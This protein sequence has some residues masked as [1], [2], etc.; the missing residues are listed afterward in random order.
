MAGRIVLCD[1]DN[2]RGALGWPTSASFRNSVQRWAS[3]SVETSLVVIAGDGRK[4]AQHACAIDASY[5]VLRT[6]SGGRWKADDTIVRDVAWWLR[7][8]SNLTICVISSDKQLRSRCRKAGN[9]A[10]AAGEG[11]KDE[12]SMRQ[13]AV[14]K[15][16]FE[17]S[18]TFACW[19]RFG[20][21]SNREVIGACRS[22]TASVPVL[23]GLVAVTDM[24][25]GGSISGACADTGGEAQEVGARSVAELA[26]G[27]DLDAGMVADTNVSVRD[28]LKTLAVAYVAWIE[29]E[30]PRPA[31]TAWEH[32]H[33]AGAQVR[34]RSGRGGKR[35]GKKVGRFR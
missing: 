22:E 32:V 3:K 34:R 6:F 15:L 21:S 29:E 9:E 25:E 16:V 26:A 19:L 17:S 27:D 7:K 8:S 1:A 24:T 13:G 31:R 33:G 14:P 5:S 28:H 10:A 20:T 30:Q 18:E 23:P 35:A 4:G 12:V 11:Q 2:V